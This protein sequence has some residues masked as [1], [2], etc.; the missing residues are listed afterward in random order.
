M[1]VS[2]ALIAFT[3]TA[4]LLTITPGLDTA[5]VLRTAAVE[6]SRRAVAA[7]LGIVLGCLIWGLTASVGLGA[8]LA[9]SQL[10]YNILRIAGAIY[11][12][13]I[14]GQ[15]FWSAIR[16]KASDGWQEMRA[17]SCTRF[18]NKR[19]ANRGGEGHS[20]DDARP[21]I[22]NAA[23]APEPHPAVLGGVAAGRTGDLAAG[24]SRHVDS[25]V[26]SQLR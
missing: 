3:L 14:G 10:G 23:G 9:A 16:G 24:Q 2:H 13:C 8:L 19:G 6:G 15:M 20:R 18:D 26:R 4:G 21:Y 25:S 12:L 17:K 22:A 7:A 11:L 5:L 1:D